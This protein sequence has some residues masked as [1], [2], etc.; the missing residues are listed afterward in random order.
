MSYRICQRVS[1][2]AARTRK[3]VSTEIGELATAFCD[4]RDRG[5]E[6][7]TRP[8]AETFI[9]AKNKRPVLNDRSSD[10]SS[11]LILC[12]RWRLVCLAGLDLCS[13]V[14][15]FV[16]VKDFV[17]EVFVSRTVPGVRSRFCAQID[18]AAGE[19]APFWPQVVVLDLEL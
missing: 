17:T 11:I 2:D 1:A 8:Q 12:K 5:V 16:R 13:L 3:P 14:K 9:T 10:S 4:G 18:H 15:E 7:C 19:L 6:Y